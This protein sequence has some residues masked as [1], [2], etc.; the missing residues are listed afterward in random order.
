MG[1]A[2]SPSRE[3]DQEASSIALPSHRSCRLISIA[4]E[5]CWRMNFNATMAEAV[6]KRSERGMT[7]KQEQG[8]LNDIR[9]LIEHFEPG[10]LV[11]K[12]PPR[13]S[14]AGASLGPYRAPPGH[15]PYR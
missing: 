15:H 2:S 5:V 13:R 8:M 7:I 10:A 6:S 12:K 3:C 11:P 14:R 4:A 9:F 1:I